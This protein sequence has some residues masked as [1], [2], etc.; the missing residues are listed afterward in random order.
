MDVRGSERVRCPAAAALFTPA[1][2]HEKVLGENNLFGLC[3][4]V[5]SVG[6]VNV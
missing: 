5:A 3:E 1:K 4:C 2:Y 6:W